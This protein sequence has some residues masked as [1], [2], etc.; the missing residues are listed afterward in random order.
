MRKKELDW[1]TIDT[2]LGVMSDRE[3]ATMYK[4]SAN[5]IRSRRIILGI[6]AYI[7]GQE[8]DWASI[9]PLLKAGVSIKDVSLRFNIPGP[10]LNDRR[11]K[12][13]IIPSKPE[14][15]CW[16][17]IDLLLGT[18][19]DVELAKE[20]NISKG[21]IARRRKQLGVSACLKWEII[22]WSKVDLYLGKYTDREIAEEAGVSEARVAS[23]RR[24]LGIPSFSGHLGSIEKIDWKAIEPYLGTM[25][26]TQ[27]AVKFNVSAQSI[28]RK[29]LDMG[30]KAYRLPWSWRKNTHLFNKSTNMQI[31]KRFNVSTSAVGAARSKLGMSEPK[32]DLSFIDQHLDVLSDAEI[33]EK[34]GLAKRTVYNRRYLVKRKNLNNST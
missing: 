32:K 20:F 28:C 6:P 8:R 26:D 24:R 9:D 33:A 17:E 10:T 29:R 15:P 18:A 30:I 12:L 27:L 31:A 21:V 13:G 4:V 19:P 16:P 11:R 22:D 23:R 14:Q 7:R 2:L 5:P 3:V 25:P 34:F 1:K